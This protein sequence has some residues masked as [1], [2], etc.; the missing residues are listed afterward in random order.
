MLQELLVGCLVFVWVKSMVCRSLY[1]KNASTQA[2]SKCGSLLH[3]Q[4]WVVLEA[5]GLNQGTLLPQL[6]L[7][8]LVYNGQGLWKR[9]GSELAYAHHEHHQLC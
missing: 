3:L 7:Q 9:E 8:R 5:C 2:G 6:Q 1:R 4:Q